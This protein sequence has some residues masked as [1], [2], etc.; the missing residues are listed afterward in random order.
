MT[1]TQSSFRA[2]I[3]R[4]NLGLFCVAACGAALCIAVTLFAIY[5]SFDCRIDRMFTENSEGRDTEL[6]II[7]SMD[8]FSIF[9]GKMEKLFSNNYLTKCAL[10]GSS[11]VSI[12][13]DLDR[14]TGDLRRIVLKAGGE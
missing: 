14:K 1:L 5:Y 11:A 6:S 7:P 13:M 2:N 8:S 3:A 9:I 10:Y 12:H 4:K